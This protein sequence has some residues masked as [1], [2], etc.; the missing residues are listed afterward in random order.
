MKPSLLRQGARIVVPLVILAAGFAAA[1]AL[2][3]SR[4]QAVR[5]P[6]ERQARLVETVTAVRAAH[7]T[8]VEAMGTVLPARRIELRPQVAGEVIEVAAEF[9]P[10]GRFAAGDVLAA[11]DPRDYELAERQRAAELAEAEAQLAL[12]MGN[13]EVARRESELL[14]D[15]VAEGRLDLVLRKP[16][17]D[18][19]RA[20][21]DAARA[22][23]DVARLALE[24]TRIRAP[25]AGVVE[26]RHVVVGSRVDA[27]TVLASLVASD[28]FWIEVA[29]PARDLRWLSLPDV[30]APRGS[31]A[32]IEDATA[33]G[34]GVFRRGFV[35]RRLVDLEP[36]GR[37]ARLLVAVPDPLGAGDTGAPPLLLGSFVRVALLG[38]TVE[39]VVIDRRVLRD[40]DSVWVMDDEDR[41]AIRRVEVGFRGREQAVVTAG[42]QGGERLVAS[43]LSTPVEGMPLRTGG[44]GGD[45]GHD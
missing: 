43:D 25:F 44:G 29:V 15:L 24:R 41:L 30:P 39:G 34:E 28:E 38:R 42:L 11:I 27:A 12:E 9:E 2:L 3:E 13:Q 16:Q 4:P 23:L 37:L 18:T 19:A 21:V 36:E 10:G 5:K 33:W 40:G 45:G 31:A 32:R 6:K 26:A 17:L 20:R 35:T 7:E 22:A 8:V 14:G 1:W